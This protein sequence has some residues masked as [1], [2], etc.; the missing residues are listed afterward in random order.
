MALWECGVL[1]YIGEKR[2]YKCIYKNL[3]ISSYYQLVLVV[4]PRIFYYSIR[5]KFVYNHTC[6][7]SP[8]IYKLHIFLASLEHYKANSCYSTWLASRW[9]WIHRPTTF[10]TDQILIAFLPLIT[11]TGT[12]PKPTN[13]CAFWSKQPKKI[14][15]IEAW[16]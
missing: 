1:S 4:T 8:N 3:G 14:Y 5:A 12:W 11:H 6:P 9:R 16:G 7:T 10:Q 2:P 15:K 13:S